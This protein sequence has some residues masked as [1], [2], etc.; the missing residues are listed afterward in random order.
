MAKNRYINTKF[1]SDGWVRKINPLDRY[2]F[3]YLL[4]NGHTNISGIYELPIETMAYES[5]LDE[6]DLEKSMLPKIEPKIYYRDGWVIIPNFIKHQ[7]QKSPTIKKGVEAELLLTP[8]KIIHFA[9]EYGYPMDTLSH[10][11]ININL[12]SNINSNPNINSNGGDKSPEEDT[13]DFS[14][15]LLAMS[16]G[17]DKRMNVIA[18]YWK[19]KEWLFSSK[20]PYQAALRRELRAASN[21]SGYSL[22]RIEQ[23]LKWLKENADFKWTLETVHKYIDESLEDI[24]PKGNR[25]KEAQKESDLIQE[26]KSKYAKP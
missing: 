5:G 2:F 14:K 16:G 1:W 21:L 12:N 26:L 15:T 9:I 17:K 22:V 4:T 25:E 23:T 19:H 7:N 8:A 11:N 6:R 18:C 3:L 10:I 20:E 24:L 13:F